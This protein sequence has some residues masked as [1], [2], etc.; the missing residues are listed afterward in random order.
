LLV[1]FPEG[2]YCPLR[3]AWISVCVPSMDV[4]P[5]IYWSYAAEALTLPTWPTLGVV[6]YP[7]STEMGEGVS[8][9]LLFFSRMAQPGWCQSSW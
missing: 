8:V 7:H 1:L 2:I 4:P 5:V 6:P 9:L 3:L